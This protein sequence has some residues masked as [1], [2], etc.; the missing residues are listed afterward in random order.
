MD[1][2]VAFIYGSCVSIPTPPPQLPPPQLPLPRLISLH[3]CSF[4]IFLLNVAVGWAI[5]GEL[6]RRHLGELKRRP[7]V[8]KAVFSDIEHRAINCK[9][10]AMVA[11]L[12]GILELVSVCAGI[13]DLVGWSKSLDRALRVRCKF[14]KLDDKYSRVWHSYPAAE[15]VHIVVAV[16]W[17]KCKVKRGFGFAYLKGYYKKTVFQGEFYL[18]RADNESEPAKQLVRVIQ[19]VKS[20]RALYHEGIQM[21]TDDQIVEFLQSVKED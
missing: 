16:E 21:Y 4:V 12:D 7:H 14:G 18:I 1:Y 8:R 17:T 2:L 15:E 10:S 6:K 9:S 3:Q 19:N 13:P 5:L 20:I 11:E